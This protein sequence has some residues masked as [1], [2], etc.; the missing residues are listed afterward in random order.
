MLVHGC[1]LVVLAMISLIPDSASMM[2]LWFF[3]HFFKS[4]FCTNSSLY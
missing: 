4:M 1:R 2:V 3:L